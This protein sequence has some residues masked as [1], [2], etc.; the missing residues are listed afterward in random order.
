MD[1]ILCH[2]VGLIL[3]KYAL[4]ASLNEARDRPVTDDEC[5]RRIWRALTAATTTP[6]PVPDKRWQELGF[7]GADP[8]TDFRG[9]GSLGAQ[10]LVAF[11][12]GHRQAGAVWREAQQG[13]HWYSFAIVAINATA[14]IYGF[15]VTGQLNRP[16]YRRMTMSRKQRVTSVAM[17]EATMRA[18]RTAFDRWYGEILVAFHRRWMEARPANLLA[19]NSIFGE[20]VQSFLGKKRV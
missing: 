1:V 8:R 15:L 5:L 19:F 17:V 7:Q 12:E 14:A 18:M 6:P 9:M 10:Q 2:A 4:V 13:P 3:A 11:A 16:L 20:T